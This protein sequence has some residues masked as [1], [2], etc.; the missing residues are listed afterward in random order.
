MSI[1]VRIIFFLFNLEIIF[2]LATLIKLKMCHRRKKGMAQTFI[3]RGNVEVKKN[4][5]LFIFFV[6]AME[7]LEI[8]VFNT[9][10]ERPVCGGG[11]IM[12]RLEKICSLL[13]TWTKNVI[14]PGPPKIYAW[15]SIQY[16]IWF[17]DIYFYICTI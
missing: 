4:T 15:H 13:L 6:P 17:D 7:K 2:H 3:I 10:L 9:K 5:S 12:K 11:V 1:F 8:L 14:A 16:S